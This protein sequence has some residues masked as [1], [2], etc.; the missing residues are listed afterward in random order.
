MNVMQLRCL[1]LITAAV[2]FAAAVEDPDLCDDSTQSCSFLDAEA[3]Q[4]AQPGVALA[5]T[6]FSR[7]RTAFPT[8]QQGSLG[9]LASTVLAVLLFLSVFF[10]YGGVQ[11]FADTSGLSIVVDQPRRLGQSLTAVVHS[12]SSEAA[13]TKSTRKAAERA[14][15]S[16]RI[17]GLRHRIVR[18]DEGDDGVLDDDR[19]S[20]KTAGFLAEAKAYAERQQ[21]EKAAKLFKSAAVMA[22]G[23]LEDL[24][25]DKHGPLELDDAK[26]Q[27][28]D[29]VLQRATFY[30]DRG[31]IK[32]AK[33]VLKRSAS[34]IEGRADIVAMRTRLLTANA[35]RD[36]G[37]VD[38]AV[39]MYKDVLLKITSGD[40]EASP[41]ERARLTVLEAETH[42]ELAR[43]ML[44]QGKTTEAQHLLEETLKNLEASEAAAPQISTLLGSRLKGWLGS[45]LLK[46]GD[47]I[48]A[49]DMLDASL[50][51]L[52]E[53]PAGLVGATTEVQEILQSRAAAKAAQ[54]RLH[55]AAED[56]EVVRGLQDELMQTIRNEHN[57]QYAAGKGRVPDPRLWTSMARTMTIASDLKLQAK[58]P[59]EALSLARKA[60]HLLREVKK[61]LRRVPKGYSLAT[62]VEVQDLMAK[63]KSQHSSAP[64]LRGTRSLP[65]GHEDAAS[66][67]DD[68]DHNESELSHAED[69][70]SELEASHEEALSSDVQPGL[71]LQTTIAVTKAAERKQ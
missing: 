41:A 51:E 14:V 23:V 55:N 71:G 59:V 36:A 22:K 45:A 34:V 64:A 18:L 20:A 44:S 69:S 40:N 9:T 39:A 60:L 50:A 15:A 1:L 48:K 57:P 61:S 5:Q 43:A 6:S 58:A 37:E 47:Y 2:A 49:V 67:A 32:A 16:L 62:F 8:P 52:G 12:W 27:L 54:G 11:Q 26:R 24:G 10:A 30:L 53:L 38:D 31:L 13:P 25:K 19:D 65:S 56:L 21:F 33:N 66:A 3:S 68:T 17:R 35:H 28:S 70:D 29:A 7:G 4:K 63:A 46:N 42:G